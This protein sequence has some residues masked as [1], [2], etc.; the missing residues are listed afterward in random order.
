MDERD[1]KGEEHQA[2]HDRG[3]DRNATG[4]GDEF[5]F[6]AAEELA[7]WLEHRRKDYPRALGIVERVLREGGCASLGERE[8]FARRLA[9]LKRKSGA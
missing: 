1:H 5:V 3:I 6:F 8:A 4:V 9:R 7:K 2:G